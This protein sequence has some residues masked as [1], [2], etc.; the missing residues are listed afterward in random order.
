MVTSTLKQQGVL[1]NTVTGPEQELLLYCARTYIDPIITQRLKFLLQ[2][3]ID[4]YYLIQIASNHGVVPMLYQNLNNNFSELV[5]RL[6]LTR[7]QENFFTNVVHNMSVT[8]EL[9]KVLEFL[10]IHNIPAIP[11]KGPVLAVLA[12]KNLALRQFGDLDILIHKQD[13]LKIKQLLLSQGY[14]LASSPPLTHIQDLLYLQAACEYRFISKDGRFAL[15]PHWNFTKKNLCISLNPEF[16]WQRLEKISFSGTTITT[17]SP[18]DSLLIVCINGTKDR[19]SSL[20]HICDVAELIRTHPQIDWDKLLAR[21]QIIGC[22]RIL[23]L[24]LFLANNLLGIELSEKIW[25]SIAT[26]AAVKNLALQVMQKLFDS[27]SYSQSLK[28][29]GSNF[30]LWEIQVRERLQDRVWY[31]L[32]LVF[33]PNEGD[34]EFLPLPPALHWVYP[35]IRPFRLIVRFLKSLS[36]SSLP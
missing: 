1:K 13:A 32:N 18:E 11:F 14:K 10:N 8:D 29:F 22:R 7:L 28:P 15:E 35:L 24:G 20:K 2:T 34:A 19:W 17:F 31:C 23:L 21:T 4:W 36:N 16:L 30:S 25:Q 33:G 9:L 26:D 12:Y 5:P 6:I 3:D 27:Y